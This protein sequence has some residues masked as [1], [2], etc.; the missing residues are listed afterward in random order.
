[1]AQMPIRWK[2]KAILNDHGITVNQFKNESGL[3]QGTAYRLA[4]GE[5]DTINSKTFEATI[6][7]LR[8]L[9]GKEINIADLV[10]YVERA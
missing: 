4:R 6:E 7:T 3:A 5:T 10:E 9:T 1:M 8:R 2:V